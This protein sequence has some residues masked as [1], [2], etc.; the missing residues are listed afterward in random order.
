MYLYSVTDKPEDNRNIIPLFPLETV[1]FPNQPLPLHIFEDR[2]KLMIG[3][4]IDKGQDFG[5]ILIQAGKL[6]QV[7]TLARIENVLERHHDGRLNILCLGK[8]RFR[9]DSLLNRR[10]FLEASVLP[11]EDEPDNEG[12]VS[13]LKHE[14]CTLIDE[15]SDLTG[16]EVHSDQYDCYSTPSYSFLLAEL[17]LYTLR[18]KQAFLEMRSNSQR[19]V[20]ALTSLRALVAK[21]KLNGQLKE[22]LGSEAD[23]FSILN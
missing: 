3:E 20:K 1:L 9:I 6:A 8:G 11:Y 23:Y 5:V 12:L 22:V 18:E 14:A 15:Y 4:C 10:P 2:Y 16:R 17:N 19:F 21:I 13:E 7:G